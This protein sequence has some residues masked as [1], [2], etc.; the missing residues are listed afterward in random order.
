MSCLDPNRAFRINRPFK[1]T[2]IDRQTMA[3]FQKRREAR[4]RSHFDQLNANGP[5]HVILI[6][7]SASKLDHP[8]PAK[9]LYTGELFQ[10]SKAYA[11]VTRHPYYILSA[12]YGL[13]EPDKTITPYNFTLKTLRQR[14]RLAWAIRVADSIV[15]HVPAGSALTI[16]AGN[17]YAAS[18]ESI[19]TRKAFTINRPLKG[20]AI[21]QQ[22]QK[23]IALIR[24]VNN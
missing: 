14:E 12:R 6:A 2:S 21:G 9:D 13:L 19:L 17:D 7:C 8:A 15:W 3:E 23:L 22:Q 1:E 11:E 5:L 4:T 16:L 10:K 18:L 20:L 24:E